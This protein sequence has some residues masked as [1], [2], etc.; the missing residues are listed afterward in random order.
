[1]DS[2]L[3]NLLLGIANIVQ[4]ALLFLIQRQAKCV[5]EEVTAIRKENG[6]GGGG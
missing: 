3:E 6:N 4:L 2:G 1:M 5:K